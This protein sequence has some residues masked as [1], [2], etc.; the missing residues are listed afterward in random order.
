MGFGEIHKQSQVHGIESEAAGSSV[1]FLLQPFTALQS[2]NFPGQSIKIFIYFFKFTNK[3]KLD[4]N[5]K[6]LL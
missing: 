3:Y 4:L 5:Y 1:L 6:H 2:K